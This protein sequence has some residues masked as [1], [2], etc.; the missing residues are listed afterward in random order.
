MT[1]AEEFASHL[2]RAATLVID[3]TSAATKGSARLET[4]SSQLAGVFDG[5]NSTSA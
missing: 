5:S 4:A 1:S 3:C 2:R